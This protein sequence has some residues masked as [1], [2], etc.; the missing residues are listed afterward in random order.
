MSQRILPEVVKIADDIKTMKIRGAGRIARAAVKGL[1]LSSKFSKANN[2]E[3]F[4]AEIDYVS[5]FL[6]KTRPTAVSLPNGI[7]YV[8]KRV[9]ESKKNV[10]NVNEIKLIA[11]ESAKQFIRESKEAVMKIGEIGARRISDGDTILTHCNSDT[12]I[13]VIKTAWKQGK[14]I[15]LYVTETRPKF[16]GRLTIKALGKTGIPITLIIDSAARHF[17]NKIDKVIVGADAVAANGSVVNKIG[18]SMVALAAKE[19]RTL[20]FV[21]TETYKFSPETVIGELVKIEERPA[22]E[23]ISRGK[24]RGFSNVK[25]RNPSFDVT[26][27][28]YIDLIITEKGVIPPEA[29]IMIIQ[30]EYGWAVSE[31][32]QEYQ[33]YS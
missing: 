28:E 33:T 19:A 8:L 20:F 11:I 24:I 7:R 10:S 12:A 27:H 4:I 26:P 18:T 17:M 25:V 6:L 3:S 16:Q 14:K 23:V 29:A 31:E 32:L 22:D 9:F 2:V 30:Q 21:A 5:K 1:L 15:Q 13:T